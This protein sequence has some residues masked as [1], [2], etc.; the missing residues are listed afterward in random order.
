MLFSSLTVLKKMM[1]CTKRIEQYNLKHGDK[2]KKPP[3]PRIPPR[4][5][6]GNRTKYKAMSL[7]S[8]HS[9]AIPITEDQNSTIVET[10]SLKY[11]TMTTNDD[12]NDILDVVTKEIQE[13]LERS[14]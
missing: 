6:F 14:L 2:P 7:F 8:N 10:Q 5:T 9:S 11:C 1:H 3:V 4:A 13:E 12:I